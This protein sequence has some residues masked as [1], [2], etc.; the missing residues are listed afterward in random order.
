MST[1]FLDGMKESAFVKAIPGTI[2][3]WGIASLMPM[4]AIWLVG[5]ATGVS[6]FQSA[7]G[8]RQSWHEFFVP[9]EV[10]LYVTAIIAPSLTY[11]LLHWRGRKHSK[12][13]NLLLIVILCV[14]VSTAIV[15]ALHKTDPTLLDSEWIPGFSNT[16]YIVSLAA[17]YLTSVYERRLKTLLGSPPPESGASISLD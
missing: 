9:N 7:A 1:R 6:E 15:Y 17:W 10:F 3:V 12:M 5:A 11:M 16:V 13:Y 14:F 8:L 4:L 2:Y